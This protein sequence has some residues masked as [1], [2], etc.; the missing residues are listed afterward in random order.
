MSEIL[1]PI[2]RLSF[3]RLDKIMDMPDLVEIQTKSYKDFL[4]IDIPENERKEIG[5]EQVFREVFPIHDF[6]ETAVL[7]Y[8]SYSLETPKYTPNEALEKKNNLCRP[9][10]N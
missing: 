10:K 5:L 7:E 3:S 6:N 8:V 1:S 9:I 4:Q 2:E